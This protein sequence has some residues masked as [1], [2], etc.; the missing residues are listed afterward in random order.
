VIDMQGMLSLAAVDAFSA[1][2]DAIFSH[3][4]NFY[5][6]DYL[7]GRRRLYLPWDLD[8]AL[9]GGG[10]NQNVYAEQSEYSRVILGVPEFR[11]QY[12]RILNDLVCGPFCEAN[13]HT[14][15]YALEPVLSDALAADPNNQLGGQSVAEFFASRRA[16][17]SER[18]QVVSSQIEGFV[19]CGQSGA[20]QGGQAVPELRL[21]PCYP[22]PFDPRTMLSFAMPGAG[23]AKVSIYD[24]R[25][26][27]IARLL[28]ETLSAGPHRVEWS[29]RDDSGRR[30]SSGTYFCRLVTAWGTETRKMTLIR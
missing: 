7:A 30:L 29:G 9:S 20:M 2:P 23:K 14:F 19:P 13:I 17:F 25:G 24:A 16:W 1:N 10:V 3:G 15:L 5:F 22:N 12:S 27:C 11:A 21:L 6:V 26:H 8:S 18:L 4:K 28:D